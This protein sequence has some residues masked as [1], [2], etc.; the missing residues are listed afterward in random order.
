MKKIFLSLAI[1]LVFLTSCTEQERARHFGGTVTINV[2]PGQKV[3]MATWKGDDLF[4]MIEPMEESYE[5]TT[6]TLVESSSY[7]VLESKIIFIESK[8]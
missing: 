5:P 7:G 6:K 2:E 3:M 8:N 4:Y 1:G